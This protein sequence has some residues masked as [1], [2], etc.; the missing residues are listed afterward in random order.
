MFSIPSI[1]NLSHLVQI[2]SGIKLN[3]SNIFVS[4]V[5]CW[6]FSHPCPSLFVSASV[7]FVLSLL[8]PHYSSLLL[9]LFHLCLKSGYFF[10]NNQF[11]EQIKGFS[12]RSPLCHV[13][14]N[15]FWSTLKIRPLILTQR[16]LLIIVTK[17]IPDSLSTWTRRIAYLFI[18]FKFL[19]SYQHYSRAKISSILLITKIQSVRLI[20]GVCQKI[21]VQNSLVLRARIIYR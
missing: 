15:F 4:F 10:Y 20:R 11:Y 6:I 12:M 16:S 21:S 1:K 8:S 7:S 19:K 9:D 2:V 18:S 17:I 5:W 14:A 13:T 3:P